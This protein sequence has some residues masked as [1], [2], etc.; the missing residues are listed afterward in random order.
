MAPPA[1]DGDQFS[2]YCVQP[3]SQPAYLVT[4]IKAV[5]VAATLFAVGPKGGCAEVR[6]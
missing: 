3:V 6:W 4:A 1:E 5:A 2:N